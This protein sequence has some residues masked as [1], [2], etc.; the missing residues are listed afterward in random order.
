MHV[1]K[2]VEEH[3]LE[4]SRNLLQQHC[5]TNRDF[6]LRPQIPSNNIIKLRNH[7][8][9]VHGFSLNGNSREK[10]NLPRRPSVELNPGRTRVGLFVQMEK[11]RTTFWSRT[12]KLQPMH[13]QVQRTTSGVTKA[14][15][16]WG[17]L[18]REWWISRFKLE[19]QRLVILLVALQICNNLLNLFK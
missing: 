13:Q 2:I 5:S 9:A 6:H 18:K 15:L 17:R 11:T 7:E 3:N 16:N 14:A 19:T 4:L 10:E 12:S 8:L 1:L